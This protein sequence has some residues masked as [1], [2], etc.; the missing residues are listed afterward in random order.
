MVEIPKGPT[1]SCPWLSSPVAVIATY[2]GLPVAGATVTLFYLGPGGVTTYKSAT[3][4]DIGLAQ[5]CIKDWVYVEAR[6][7]K[8]G[9]DF[10]SGNG[11]QHKIGGKSG[12]DRFVSG[13]FF[14]EALSCKLPQI[15]NPITGK[16]ETPAPSLPLPC[17]GTISIAEPNWTDLIS[18]PSLPGTIP[19][20]F[21]ITADS[22]KQ[23]PGSIPIDIFVDDSRA[24]YLSG[25]PGDNSIDIL[26]IIK[27]KL[28]VAGLSK[29]HRI[30]IVAKPAD[31]KCN[32][33]AQ[34]FTLP[35]LLPPC[36][37]LIGIEPPDFTSLLSKP[38]LPGSIPVPVTVTG[39]SLPPS[40]TLSILVDGTERTTRT[41]VKDR[42]INIDILSIIR[43][44]PLG[45][46]ALKDSHKIDIKSKLP[47]CD[48]LPAFIDIPALV[49]EITEIIGF[50]K[51]IIKIP[52]IPKPPAIP[53]PINISIDG[54]LQGG[55]P[56][57]K[58]VDPGTHNITVELKG[59]ENIYRKVY[60]ESGETVT[61]TDIAFIKEVVKEVCEI[62]D[63]QTISCPDG[64]VV[65][66]AICE[67]DPVTGL[68]R[69]VPTYK[70]CPI[71]PPKEVC[72]IGQE[73]KIGCPD[74]TE[75]VIEKCEKDPT[76]GRNRWVPTGNTCPP[77][78][79]GKVVKILTYPE[80]AAL[81][82][83]DGQEVT[84]T[85]SVV[86]GLTLSTGETAAFEVDG[87]KVASGTTS[88]GTIT[89]KWKATS[90]PSRTHKLCVSVPKSAQCPKYGSARD[91]KTITVSRIIPGI[92][93]QLIKERQE[94][95]KGLEA[96][97][98]ERERI[99]TLIQ[100]AISFVPTAPV[101]PAPF[102]PTIPT[103]PTIP[104]VPTGPE[105]PKQGKISI[106]SVEI[107]P[108]VV[109]PVIIYIDGERIGSPPVML[110]ADPGTHTVRIELKGFTPISKKI[111]VIAG[112]TTQV[113]DL[114]FV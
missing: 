58:E 66:T 49:P 95:A 35:R 32:I 6:I 75:I 91:C 112:E 36:S 56:I 55:P 111:S 81:E 109:F 73:R 57:S 90:E 98:Q 82:A 86:C 24:L 51:G 96:L 80:G 29:E 85:A 101:I 89:F 77:V 14:I 3:T 53:Y 16:C 71:I 102:V 107:L 18:K 17:G 83:F 47:D 84:V 39:K 37:G 30:S 113:T 27:T 114:R 67:K 5:E 43:S 63:Q 11:V 23:I 33:P 10:G 22:G 13:T 52:S 104:T 38:S 62:G 97:R 20:P 87:V 59:M 19:V 44:L 34:G 40:M 61:I 108:G 41:V 8:T 106:P 68:N 110:D 65:V 74:G 79:M 28:G 12:P 92:E 21:T 76:T 100:P 70:T 46:A 69:F 94:Y 93:E 54:I 60:V 72:E 2:A 78:E 50:L 99:R 105:V 1:I 26:S 64:T 7:Q 88:N 42:S 15:Y 25:K 31:P 4:N 9:I 48:I 45:A 103:I